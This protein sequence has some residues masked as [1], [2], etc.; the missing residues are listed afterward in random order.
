MQ[1]Y[2]MLF[3]S[4]ICKRAT[5]GYRNNAALCHVDIFFFFQIPLIFPEIF[6]F[7]TDKVNIS[8]TLVSHVILI[9]KIKGNRKQIEGELQV[10]M[11]LKTVSQPF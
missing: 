3:T 8:V 1:N 4:F 11:S 6:C 9:L 10:C 7:N 5:G 2:L